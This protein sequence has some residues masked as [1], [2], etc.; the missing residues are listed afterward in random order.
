VTTFRQTSIRAHLQL[1]ARVLQAIRAFF[2]AQGY[3][4]VETPYRLPAP[5]PEA[6]IE[7]LPCEGG[8]LHTSPELCM[9]RLLAAGYPRIY[10]VCRCFRAGERG[11]RHLPEFTLLE[12]YTAGQAFPALMDQTE[13]LVRTV[14]RAVGAPDRLVYQG[15]GIHLEAPFRRLTVADA[16][17]RYAGRS[18]AD[19]LADERFDELMGLA[20][21][22]RLGWDL[23]VLLHDYPAACAALARRRP[24]DPDLAER[25]ELYIAGLEL[26]NGFGELT[27][28]VEQRA[29]FKDELA[30]RAAAGRRPTPLPEPFLAALA[31]MPPAAGNALGVDRLVM[32]LADTPNIDDVT[33]FTPEEL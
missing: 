20:I 10:Q 3:L 6:H 26:C 25:F 7:P 28:P 19:A 18:A 16:F 32:L 22:P 5:A 14:A 24:A 31:H 9:K 8:F 30:R 12:W 33:A 11:G 27:D 23:P 2:E 21:E 1:R 4:E 17:T 13:D 15:Q 29:R